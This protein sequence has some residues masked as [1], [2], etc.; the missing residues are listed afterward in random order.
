LFSLAI[1]VLLAGVAILVLR[2]AEIPFIGMW[3]RA[4]SA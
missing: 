4:Q 1:A 3:L 2:R